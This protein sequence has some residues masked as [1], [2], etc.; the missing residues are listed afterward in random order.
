MNERYEYTQTEFNNLLK[1]VATFPTAFDDFVK[2]LSNAS[3]MHLNIRHIYDLNSKEI[4]NSNFEY[5]SII[6]CDVYDVVFTN[7]IFT[8]TTFYMSSIASS[9][10]NKCVFSHCDFKMTNMN[11]VTLSA[12]SSVTECIAH[13]SKFEH[14]TMTF[15]QRKNIRMSQCI[16]THSP[17]DNEYTFGK[18]LTQP[19]IGYKKAIVVSHSFRI[20]VLIKL[21]IPKGAI[22][23]QPNYYKC[24]TNT[25]KVLRITNLG[26]TADYEKACSWYD[27]K[28]MYHVGETIACN[29][30]NLNNTR[31]CAEGIHF[32]LDK[33][34]ALNYNWS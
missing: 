22:V 34:S 32:F 19:L 20:G 31:E 29:D 12:D 5:C 4:H 2:K 27:S 16:R 23:F 25:A 26:E 30:F 7:C 9:K 11:Y 3:F 17:N 18:I 24:R 21:E 10:F 14:A 1:T 6:H 15:D 13:C 28:F 8:N 33:E